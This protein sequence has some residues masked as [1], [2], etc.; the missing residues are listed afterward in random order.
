MREDLWE[1]EGQGEGLYGGGTR[2][3]QKSN[4]KK[5]SRHL[6]VKFN[7]HTAKNIF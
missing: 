5:W 2:H 4:K 6:W 1:E 3:I 7:F